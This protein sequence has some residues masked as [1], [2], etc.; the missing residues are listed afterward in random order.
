MKESLPTVECR[1]RNAEPIV[2]LSGGGLKPLSADGARKLAA[3]LTIAADR[4][5]QHVDYGD[6][7]DLGPITQADIEKAEAAPNSSR[8]TPASKTQK[9]SIK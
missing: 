6:P 8:P 7:L 5:D 9:G 4:V 3:M 2:F 1:Y